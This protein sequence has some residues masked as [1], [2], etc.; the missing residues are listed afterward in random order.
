MPCSYLQDV[1]GGDL[2]GLGSSIVQVL[3]QHLQWRRTCVNTTRVR[4][5]YT[6]NSET[7]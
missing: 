4:C 6:A 7:L 3:H 5:R 2:H 1:S